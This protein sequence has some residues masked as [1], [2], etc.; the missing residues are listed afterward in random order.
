MNEL[1]NPINV[2][3]DFFRYS[4]L[5]SEAELDLELSVMSK[6][7]M[8]TMGGEGAV[9]TPIQKLRYNAVMREGGVYRGRIAYAIGLNNICPANVAWYNLESNGHK[10][11]EIIQIEKDGYYA[12]LKGIGYS[13]KSSAWYTVKKYAKNDAIDRGL[14]GEIQPKTDADVST[15]NTETVGETRE[16]HSLTLCFVED[17]TRLHNRAL[18]THKNKP[19]EY[20]ESCRQAH[21][22]IINAMRAM[23][24]DVG[25]VIQSDLK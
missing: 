1:I 17:L 23:K 5:G 2:S 6:A 7:V 16:M 14:F 11:P 20:T 12:G 22:F 4:K 21:G 8:E 10:L 9:L 3:S 18:R 19:E 24:L 25:I 13:N 15:I